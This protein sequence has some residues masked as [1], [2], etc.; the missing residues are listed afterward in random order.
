MGCRATSL[1]ER[2]NARYSPQFCKPG[3]LTFDLKTAA[4]HRIA[5]ADDDT[6]K[7]FE[8]NEEAKALVQTLGEEF[9]VAMEQL[10]AERMPE[11]T[12]FRPANSGNTLDLEQLLGGLDDSGWSGPE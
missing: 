7:F 4:A 11:G 5:F 1:D 10:L 8:E 6:L 9:L 2:G 12:F 3:S